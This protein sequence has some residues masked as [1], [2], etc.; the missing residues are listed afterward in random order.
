MS[1]V[2]ELQPI[3]WLR[4]C[5]VKCSGSYLAKDC[6]KLRKVEPKCANCD[7]GHTTNYGKC[8]SLLLEK[9]T[10]RQLD[11]TWLS[12]LKLRISESSK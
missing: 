4:L 10:Y 12:L 9:E 3:L 6:L 5:S 11:S 2:R 1:A 8:P 7:G